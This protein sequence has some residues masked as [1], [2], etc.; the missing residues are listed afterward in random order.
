MEKQQHGNRDGDILRKGEGGQKGNLHDHGDNSQRKEGDLQNPGILMRRDRR[1][2][3]GRH[4]EDRYR[5][6]KSGRELLCRLFDTGRFFRDKMN[7]TVLTDLM[8]MT[9]L[10]KLM[11]LPRTQEKMS[12]MA[13]EK[14]M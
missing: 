8:K 7:R 6:D 14:K 11:D 3:G 12:G 9:D 4:A 13:A 1:G 10:M 2:T 5:S